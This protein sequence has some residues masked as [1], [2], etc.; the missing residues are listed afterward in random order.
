MRSKLNIL[1][2]FI[3]FLICISCSDENSEPQSDNSSPESSIQTDKFSQFNW[4]VKETKNIADSRY[5]CLTN[6]NNVKFEKDGSVVLRLTKNGDNWEGGE[7]TIDTTLGYGD[8]IFEISAP[9]GSINPNANL[10]LSIINVEEDIFEGMTQT[11]VRFSKYSEP[12]ALNELEYYLYA[13]DKKIA[14]V[15]TPD[16]P[17]TLTKNTSLHKIG[18]YPDHLIY[19][20]KSNNFNN[21]TK[22]LKQS[23]VVDPQPDLL[24]FSPSTNKLKVNISFCFAESNEPLGNN[25][26]SIRIHSFKYSPAISGLAIK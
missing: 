14:E 9:E 18:I 7:L 6:K 21:E 17:F 19:T 15:Q 25:G 10:S 24:S 4:I 5:Y 2:A 26:L 20:S 8:Y 3:V 11:G 13:T 1:S 12:D 22:I 16:N 23:T